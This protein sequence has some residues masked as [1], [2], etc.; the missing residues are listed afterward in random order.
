MMKIDWPSAG[1]YIV[2]VSGGVDS[3]CLLNLLVDH[4]G[5]D[6]VVAHVDHGIRPDSA[7]DAIL[8]KNLAQ[9]YNLPFVTTKLDL[10]P[11]ASEEAARKARYEFL[12]DQ[13]K[14]HQA[15]AILTAHHAD[16]LLETS[17]LNM[18]RG[19]DRYGALGGMNRE[20][21]IRPLINVSKK[22]LLDCAAQHNLK[23]NEDSTNQ[24]TKYARNQV[25]HE[26]IPKIDVN[27]YKNHMDELQEVSLQIDRL[28][29]PFV[30]VS[31]GNIILQ[32][33][34]IQHLSLR[35]L[36]VVLAYGLR[37]IRPN[38]ELSQPRI[39]AAAREIMLGTD[40]ISFSSDSQ[41]G[42]IVSIQ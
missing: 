25:R 23:W 27:D 26:V 6:L 42:I 30:S 19:T 7:E 41:N 11:G 36:E 29:E 15:Q 35:E 22:E 8:V 1:K 12:F 9:S 31:E 4:D 28:V 33:D 21:I 32:R 18:R 24:D 34:I 20:G 17:I 3:V 37:Q 38:L 39:A 13:L 10:G 14:I 16:D 5:Y 40:K 2:A